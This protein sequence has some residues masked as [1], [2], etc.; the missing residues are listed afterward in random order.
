MKYEFSDLY[1]N[2]L[3]LFS[4]VLNK[5]I[6]KYESFWHVRSNYSDEWYNFIVPCTNVDNFEWAKALQIHQDEGAN[7]TKVSF[8]INDDLIT[9]YTNLLIKHNYSSIGDDTYMLKDIENTLEVRYQAQIHQL[10]IEH[11]EEYLSLSDICFPEW[12]SNREYGK[13]FFDLSINNPYKNKDLKTFILQ[14][15]GKLVGFS[16]IIIDLDVGLAYLHNS[17]VHPDYRKLGY[18]TALINFRCNYALNLGINQ[19]YAIVEEKSESYKNFV[20]L[21][22]KKTDKF[23]M[24][25]K[26]V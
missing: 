1:I 20:K 12:T 5:E 21:G 26:K 6:N 15:D 2:I 7:G 22:Y 3:T 16:S 4:G 17:G 18:H 14:I 10:T 8:Y 9:D 11:L 13:H 19:V 25:Y 24:F 23:H